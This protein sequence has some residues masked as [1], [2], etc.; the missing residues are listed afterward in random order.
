MSARTANWDRNRAHCS[1]D[2]AEEVQIIMERACCSIQILLT[3]F[4]EY[5][6]C[7]V[8]VLKMPSPAPPPPTHTHPTPRLTSLDSLWRITGV[9]TGV[10]INNAE[11][12]CLFWIQTHPK[13]GPWGIELLSQNVPELQMCSFPD[14]SHPTTGQAGHLWHSQF[15]VTFLKPFLPKQRTDSTWVFP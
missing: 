5:H 9:G 11:N 12:P 15:S 4:V 2:P 8:D 13:N 3:T 14:R 1:A 10:S 6:A 7:S